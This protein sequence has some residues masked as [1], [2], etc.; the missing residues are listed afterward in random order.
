MPNFVYTH[1][2]VWA[3]TELNTHIPSESLCCGFL[4]C[5]YDLV[6][7]WVDQLKEVAIHPDYCQD[8]SI[9][10]AYF[11]VLVMLM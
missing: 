1:L 2:Q 4:M 5:P 11:Q 8:K 10:R 7:I 6:F 9:S 3:S